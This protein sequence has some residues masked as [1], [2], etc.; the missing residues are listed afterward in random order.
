[1]YP[2]QTQ[3]LFP[4]G[5][6]HK[7]SES[8]HVSF[9]SHAAVSPLPQIVQGFSLFSI[10]LLTFNWQI[11]THGEGKFACSSE[12]KLELYGFNI[13]EKMVGLFSYHLFV[14]GKCI[15]FKVLKLNC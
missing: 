10:C 3:L 1:M 12:A 6:Y 5:Y 8:I 9:S 2:S 14:V 11:K 15:V 7:S 4:L 13:S